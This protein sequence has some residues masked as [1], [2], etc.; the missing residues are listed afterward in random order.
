MAL[1]NA[2]GAIRIT[3]VD[4]LTRTGRQAPDGSLYAVVSDPDALVGYN[5]ACG[6][7]NVVTAPEGSYSP[8]LY[9]SGAQVVT[10]DPT[11][12][13]GAM[14]VEAVVGTLGDP[15]LDIPDVTEVVIEGTP[16]VGETV[17]A[18]PT[19][20]G[21][22]TITYEWYR[23]NG[24]IGGEVTSTYELSQADLN[25]LISA[26]VSKRNHTGGKSKQSEPVLVT[27]AP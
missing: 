21:T 10:E 26:T 17:T 14:L 24:K 5:H 11:R 8:S 4:G 23:G 22:G 7:M 13:D 9:P 12:H 2:S 25:K 16:E 27:E 20:T 6:A 3:I 19:T 15:V 18:T 1:R